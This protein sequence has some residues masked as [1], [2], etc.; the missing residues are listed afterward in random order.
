MRRP[1]TAISSRR[2]LL[3]V[4][5]A[6]AGLGGL[7]AGCGSGGKA[8]SSASTLASGGGTQ[9][10][11]TR[12]SR[13]RASARFRSSAT[14][15]TVVTT[16]ATATS[17][18]TS[19]APAFAPQESGEGALAAAAATVRAKGYT[20]T[21]TVQY[22]PSQTLRVLTAYRTG[23]GGAY[24]QRAFFFVDGRYIGT[25]AS[26]P[27]ASLRVLSQR[28]TTVTLG[29]G[30]YR[31][32][33]PSSRPSGGEASVRFQLDD[34]RLTARDPIPPARSASGLARR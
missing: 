17:T 27:S 6:L 33:D 1:P 31:E 32:G 16:T 15:V 8:G 30:L 14:S 4:S 24:E 3:G 9:T 10:S 28:E 7:L 11:A 22:H 13:P 20:P 19:S 2:A 25:D 26:Q 29:Y 34:G 18:R 12:S 23:A 5:C 21:D